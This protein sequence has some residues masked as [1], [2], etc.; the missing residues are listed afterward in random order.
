MIAQNNHIKTFT[1]DSAVPQLS[2]LDISNN[3]LTSLPQRLAS[4]KNSLEAL[5]LSRLPIGLNEIKFFKNFEILYEVNLTNTSIDRDYPSEVKVGWRAV[6][7]LFNNLQVPFNHVKVLLLGNTNIGKSNLLYYWK[8]NKHNA[9]SSNLSTHGI[10]YQQIKKLIKDTDKQPITLHV[11][12]FGGQEYFHATHKLFF[13]GG[14]INLLLW[15]SSENEELREGQLDKCFELYYWLRCIEQLGF[16]IDNQI[17]SDAIVVENKIDK[18]GYQITP[19]NQTQYQVKY[20]NKLSLHYHAMALMPDKKPQ[21][22]PKRLGGLNELLLEI[23]NTKPLMR[24]QRYEYVY[25]LIKSENEAIVKTDELFYGSINQEDTILLQ[26]FHNMGLLL[27]FKDIT[28]HLIFAK[29]KV[30]LDFVYKNILS[31]VS[32][33]K[34]SED[35]IRHTIHR[36]QFTVFLNYEDLIKILLSF[37]LIFTIPSEPNTFF[38]PQ[39]LP[40]QDGNRKRE[41]REFNSYP[42]IIIESDSYLMNLVML[43][44]YGKF[45]CA[46]EV[47]KGSYLFWNNGIIIDLDNGN[48]LLIKFDREQQQL[49][50][51]EKK[52]VN[53]MD[54]LKQVVDFVIS[55]P[56]KNRNLQDWNSDYFQIYLS[57]EKGLKVN[58]RNLKENHDLRNQFCKDYNGQTVHIPA[59]QRFLTPQKTTMSITK[60]AVYHELVQKLKEQ[61][62][63]IFVG[64]GVSA[65]TTQNEPLSKWRGLLENGV[66]YCK[67]VANCDD[68]WV[69]RKREAIDS[70]ELEEWLSV[71]EHITNKLKGVHQFKTWLRNKVGTLPNNRPELINKIG[72]LDTQIYTTNYDKLLNENLKRGIISNKD[73]DKIQDVVNGNR[74]EIVHLHGYYD[75]ADTVILGNISYND[76]KHD[77]FFQAIEKAISLSKY[78]LFIG[79]GAGLDDP[80]FGPLFEWSKKVINSEHHHYRL[81]LEKDKGNIPLDRN[82]QNL[83]YGSDYDDIYTFMCELVKDV[84]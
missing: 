63:V 15:A 55:I 28:P 16:D 32:K 5:D 38:I 19:I 9:N 64:T 31:D 66:E 29:P 3:P 24:P 65:Y 25:S 72:E 47:K 84:R 76:L 39:Y 73:A 12:D 35:E 81:I 70:N 48:K 62:V 57:N 75:D 6:K 51:F 30:F 83:V 27:Y 18:K 54:I 58:F 14:A 42:S 36:S 79:F 33:W 8:N 45:G 21:N 40:E 69:R 44:I 43:K 52:N 10:D 80:N 26:V 50:L 49:N 67:D 60:G 78:I 56:E 4:A 11:W 46:V 53:T 59:F 22:L 23:I 2:I 68:N 41:E 17:K 74:N 61:K 82:I 13:S 7:T 34:L 1:F 37:D 77:E 20:G 71:A